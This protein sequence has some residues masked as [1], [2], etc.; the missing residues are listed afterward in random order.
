[1]RTFTRPSPPQHG[2]ALLEALI[3]FLL[4]SIGILALSWQQ[5]GLRQNS[6]A[7]RQRSEA[8]RLAQKDIEDLRAFATLDAWDDI[9][10]ASVDATPAGS[11]T[12]Y[13]L[14]RV[15]QTRDQPALKSVRVTLG[16]NDRHGAAQQLVL[17]TLIAGQDPALAG[18][19]AQP[20]PAMT[21]P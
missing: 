18:A 14:T 5:G 11:P 8:V 9:A 19:L 7:A 13:T 17:D 12:H 6:D 21:R 4:L 16:W 1:M 15:V 20:H 2:I 3:A 10:D